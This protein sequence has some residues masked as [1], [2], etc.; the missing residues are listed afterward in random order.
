MRWWFVIFLVLGIALAGCE[1]PLSSESFVRLKDKGEDGLY[2]Y[3]VD[4][5]DSLCTYDLYF[6]SRIDCSSA[7]LAHVRDFPMIVTW[8]APD[9]RRFDEK[10]FF[11][12]HA[13]TDDSGFYSKSYKILYRSGLAPVRN[14]EWKMTVRI[15]SDSFVPGFRGLGVICKKTLI[16]GTR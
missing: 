1:R 2:H 4:M 16:D 6:Y 12:V 13:A 9:G 7:R 11:D 14:G 3:T 15:D 8:T 5:T 10:V